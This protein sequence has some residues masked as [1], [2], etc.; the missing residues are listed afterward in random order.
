MDS[1]FFNMEAMQLYII[2]LTVKSL[3][4]VNL[5]DIV[6]KFV[7]QNLAILGSHIAAEE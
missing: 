2:S 4:I 7:E 1:G 5:R 6:E 3:L